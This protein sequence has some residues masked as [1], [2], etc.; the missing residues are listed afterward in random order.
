MSYSSNK[1]QSSEKLNIAI[2][3]R[4]SSVSKV[5]TVIMI[6]LF[7]NIAAFY[8]LYET[9][10]LFDLLNTNDV[11]ILLKSLDS[12]IACERSKAA[13]AFQK[14]G[15]KAKIAVPKLL[16]LLKDPDDSVRW[17]SVA[18][19]GYLCEFPVEVKKGIYALIS[20]P[21]ETVRYNTIFAM[22]RMNICEMP[23]RDDIKTSYVE[24]PDGFK[25]YLAALNDPVD[26][27]V[28]K[29]LLHLDCQQVLKNGQEFLSRFKVK[30]KELSNSG[31]LYIKVL[32]INRLIKLY[33]VEE[34]EMLVPD[35][36]ELL[37]SASSSKEDEV[38]D[39]A[40]ESLDILGQ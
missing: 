38:R 30:L 5:R 14:L 9:C 27:I 3:R 11:H 36:R 24:N 31:N 21:N 8:L 10:V 17:R 18:A 15:D 2:R 32:S 28:H 25:A 40:R 12:K 4:S 19:L 7:F 6:L 20:D 22:G 34:S 13:F 35:I 29:S 23:N 33:G 26:N 16:E 37:I 39:F 1:Q